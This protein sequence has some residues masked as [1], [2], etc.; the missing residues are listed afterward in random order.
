[1]GGVPRRFQLGSSK[2]NLLGGVYLP[3]G[4]AIAGAF[5]AF[6]YTAAAVRGG[7]ASV[8]ATEPAPS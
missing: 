1:M 6:R 5:V 4:R 2:S 3:V 7:A 8:V